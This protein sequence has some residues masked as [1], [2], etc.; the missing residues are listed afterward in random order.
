MDRSKTTDDFNKQG[1]SN[2][3]AR[4]Y[5]PGVD[6]RN[7]PESLESE[8]ENTFNLDVEVFGLF[9]EGWEINWPQGVIGESVEEGDEFDDHDALAQDPDDPFDY[10]GNSIDS[11]DQAEMEIAEDAGDESEYYSDFNEQLPDRAFESE[12]TD[13][14][15]NGDFVANAGPKQGYPDSRQPP[16]F[17]ALLGRDHARGEA[18]NSRFISSDDAE[19]SFQIKFSSVSK[20]AI[21]PDTAVS[22]SLEQQDF[23]NHISSASDPIRTAG[24]NVNRALGDNLPLSVPVQFSNVDNQVN[25]VVMGII[26][27]VTC[28]ATVMGSYLINLQSRIEELKLLQRSDIRKISGGK[29]NLETIPPPD[30]IIEHPESWMQII[31]QRLDRALNQDNWKELNQSSDNPPVQSEFQESI[32]QHSQNTDLRILEYHL[33]HPQITKVDIPIGQMDAFFSWVGSK[34]QFLRRPHQVRRDSNRFL[35]PGL[36]PA[37]ENAK[38]A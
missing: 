11:F 32:Y 22:M 14:E 38:F 12:N 17:S 6:E 9:D 10:I 36:M 28:L 15:G 3:S 30:A 7:N 31:K 18:L 27:L 1:D 8:A 26:V 33:K 2:T 29:S 19:R 35:P 21:K 24:A 4:N 23:E 37:G 34:F 16:S 5:P 13:F 20:Y 25:G